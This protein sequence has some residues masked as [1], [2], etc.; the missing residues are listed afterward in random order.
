MSDPTI[1]LCMI[2]KNEEENI[3]EAICS[4][5]DAVEQI[6][7]VDTGSTD[8]TREIA[9]ELGAEVYEE[10]WEDDFSKARNAGIERATGEWIM[11]L[12]ADERFSTDYVNKLK[13]VIRDNP[14]GMAVMLPIKNIVDNDTNVI[15]WRASAFKNHP[16]IRYSGR[17]HESVSM[18]VK[19]LGGTIIKCD[20]PIIHHGYSGDGNAVS[21]AKGRNLELLQKGYEEEPDNYVYTFYLGKTYL[22]AYGDYAKAREYLQKTIELCQDKPSPRWEATFYLGM[23]EEKEKHMKEALQC[24]HDVMKED[25]QFPDVYYV[26][27]YLYYRE[28][29]YKTALAFFEQV[30]R[31]DPRF[32]SIAI[33]NFMF[34]DKRILDQLQECSALSGDFGK[35][36]RYKMKEVG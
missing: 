8:R 22:T 15:H 35:C 1:T 17:V 11:I 2:V 25:P 28:Q 27:G 3:K 20:L 24:W 14:D 7:V 4:V 16:Q 18:A 6:V 13:E 19:A 33:H 34:T 36:I 12:D 26:L 21:K 23:V 9:A 5:K 29:K 30:L 31:C 10:P 32:A